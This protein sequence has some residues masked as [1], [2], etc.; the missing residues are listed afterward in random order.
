[1]FR[2]MLNAHPELVAPPE[3]GFIEWNFSRFATATFTEPA[4]VDDFV[5]AVLASKKMETWG[6]SAPSLRERLTLAAKEHRQ[7]DYTGAVLAVFQAYAEKWGKVETKVA[8]DKNNYYLK[9][10]PTL[11]QATPNAGILHLVRDVRDVACSYL[12]LADAHFE[13]QYAPRLETDVRQ[14][15][16]A[17]VKNNE[18]IVKFVQGK[19]SLQVHYED[20]ILH[21]EEQLGRVATWLGVDY[22]DNMGRYYEFNDEPA[23]TVAWK[24]KTLEPVDKNRMGQYAQLLTKG[25]LDLIWEVAGELM[26]ALGYRA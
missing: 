8:V 7:L 20:L 4:V 24:Q 14:I 5:E 1:M 19:R 3:C 22:H 10:L 26:L 16:E 9:V 11:E 21:P 13:S 18:A 25:E 17:W 23:A 2:L 15:A 12:A 6:L